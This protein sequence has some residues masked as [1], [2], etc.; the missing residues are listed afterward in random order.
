MQETVAAIA[1]EEMVSVE[2]ERSLVARARIWANSPRGAVWLDAFW[3]FLLTR[4]VF[5]AVTYL[6]PNLFPGAGIYGPHAHGSLSWWST[7]DATQ[8]ALIATQG[9][10][11]AWLSAYWPMMPAL[12]HALAPFFGGDPRFSGLLIANVSGFAMLVLLRRLA[13]RELGVETARRAILYIAVFPTAFYLFAPYAESLFLALT[14]GSFVALRERRWL[15]A[16][17]L[18]GLATL[19][20]SNG[21]L[22]T[23]PFAL[24]FYLAWRAGL[25]RWWRVVFGALIPAGAG[26]F[27]LYCWSRFG[28][29]LAFA[30]AQSVWHRTAQAPWVTLAN[31]VGG[32][33]HPSSTGGVASSHLL[34]NL[35]AVVVF[36]GLLIPIFRM[37][38]MSYG[39]YSAAVIVYFLIFAVAGSTFALQG[40]GR[41]VLM[42]FPAFMV[43]GALAR[44]RWM[45]EGFLMLSLPLLTILAGHY[46]LG[47]ALG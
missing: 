5:L 8:F 46:L 37:L 28:D 40:D 29:P 42:V 24:E 44:R 16:G 19:T 2:I 31:A 20:K 1:A 15:M 45:H 34:L 25:A 23:I 4:I 18:G 43:L 11:G 3:V 35:A 9:Y 7:Q 47:L 6:T 22:L 41:Y 38:P 27:A 39:L 13:E 10:H 32:L 21:I 17:L 30:H 36:I 33:I 12:M 26:A 14:I